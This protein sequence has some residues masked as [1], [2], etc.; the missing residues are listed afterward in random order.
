MVTLFQQKKVNVVL[1]SGKTFPPTNFK[2]EPAIK[3][4]QISGIQYLRGLAAVMVVLA[5][6]SGTATIPKYFGTTLFN[7][8]LY[9]GGTGVHL[10]FVISGFIIV[11]VS[12][13]QTTLATKTG[14]STFLWKRFVRIIPFMWV[15]V[16]GHALLMLMGRP[17]DFQWDA[18]LHSLFLFPVGKMLPNVTWTLRHE[19]IFYLIFCLTIVSMKRQWPLLFL[20]VVSPLIWHPIQTNFFPRQSTITELGDLFFSPFNLLFGI[21]VSIGLL[22]LKG[23]LPDGR[24]TNCGFSFCILL[25][26]SL[27]I[28]ANFLSPFYATN[29]LFYTAALGMVSGAILLAAISI[30]VKICFEKLDEFG[31]LLGNASYAI[32]LTHSAIISS[33]FG[34]WAK[35]QKHPNP[36]LLM[37]ITT[38][39][40]CVGGIFVHK[41]IEKPLIRFLQLSIKKYIS[42]SKNVYI[43]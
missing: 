20:W 42:G 10:F 7:G 17:G 38:T 21:G 32:Y 11:Y 22:T 5:H 30:N 34:V 43:N 4:H 6:V 16:I 15:C 27:L 31:L 26:L 25:T 37:A 12:L 39:C 1:E 40:C 36:V 9:S 19:F 14:A 13:S 28:T 29:K 2:T 41:Q 35:F 3:G 8:A 18:Y 24:K 23:R 33:L